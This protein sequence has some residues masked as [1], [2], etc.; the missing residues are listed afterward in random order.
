[1]K[2]GFIGL[3]N[4]GRPMARNLLKG[5]FDLTV[6]NRTTPVAREL[7]A[8]GAK[9]AS[10][11]AD[12]TQRVDV[13]LTCVSNDDSLEEVVTGPNGVLN[14]AGETTTIVDHSTVSPGLSRRLAAAAAE[15]GAAYL[16]APVS[17]GTVGAEAG[18]LTFMIGGEEG[19]LDRVR[20][21]LAAMGKAVFHCGDVGA[22]NVAKLVNNFV[23]AV[24]LMAAVE[25]MVMGVKAGV[26]ARTLQQV[27]VASTGSSKAFEFTVPNKIL[28]RDFEPGFAIDLMLKDLRLAEDLARSVDTPITTGSVVVQQFVEAQCKGLG[29]ADTSAM[30][31]PLEELTGVILKGD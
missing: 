1:M 8:E 20:P 4:M 25:G 27:V 5:G 2:I 16:D 9:V 31:R 15:R 13:V 17:G 10:S 14:A 19:H 6:F 29:N 18:T 12:L 24:N 30:A 21:V 22:G 26:D 3:G 23:G 28:Q 7:E 11:P